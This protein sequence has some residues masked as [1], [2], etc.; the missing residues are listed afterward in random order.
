MGSAQG[1]LPRGNLVANAGAEEGLAGWTPTGT[2]T[3][4]QYPA[5]GK[6]ERGASFFSG[7]SQPP[8]SAAQTVDLSGGRTTID[9][10]RM[11]ALVGARLAGPA[12]LSVSTV[13]G[14]GNTLSQRNVTG[15]GG[16]F[17]RTE[18]LIPIPPR[19]RTATLTLHARG[20]GASFDN[21]TFLA[22]RR[23]VPRPER[24][25]SVLVEPA[26]GITVLLRRG[27]RKTITR[28]TLVPLGSVL[29][30]SRG[31]ATVVS[32]GDRYGAVTE[33]GSFSQGVFAVEQVGR[34]TRILLGGRR[35]R[36]CTHPRHLVSHA[37][38]AFKVLAGATASRAASSRAVWVA[39]D[40]CTA[41]TVEAH[42]GSV[43]L[44]A[45]GSR[46][47][48]SG[49]LVRRLSAN[50]RRGG[51]G[52]EQHGGEGGGGGPSPSPS[53]APRGRGQRSATVRG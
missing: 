21:V 10:G 34:E 19:A 13:D 46:R 15:S 7:G 39:K 35:D 48:T 6:P 17:E 1:A 8:S 41:T 47:A 25:K 23:G 40:E 20:S 31:T 49:P 22:T 12:A 36:S 28:P 44:L 38:A 26:K 30:T 32:A 11:D 52:L 29:D 16:G 37:Q 3:V 24:G 53:P 2:F 42:R 9:A 51:R 50:V 33:R 27:N 43:D 5:P 18:E 4:Q 14:A 45:V